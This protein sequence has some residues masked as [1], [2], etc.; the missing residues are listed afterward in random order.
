MAL[1]GFDPSVLLNYYAVKLTPG[2]SPGVASHARQTQTRVVPPWDLSIKK[3]PQ[4]KADVAARSG[5]P[6]FDPK[7]RSLLAKVDGPANADSQ[8]AAL[9]Q[10][11]LAHRSAGA[12]DNPGLDADNNRLFALYKALNRLDSIARM[13]NREETTNGRRPGLNG[14]FQNGLK[15][16]VDFVKKAEFNNLTVLPNAKASTTQSAVAIAYPKLNYTSGPV[17][18]DDEVFS[19]VPNVTAADS[20]TISVT[21]AGV[22]TDVDIDLANVS[23]TLTLDNINAYVNQQLEAGGFGTRFARV[24]TGGSIVEGTAT[25]GTEIRMA[26]SEVINLSS[27]QSSPAVYVAGSTGKGADLQGRVI[28]LGDLD[29]AITSE[30]AANITPT[31][32]TAAAKASAIDAN[33]NVYVV[34]NSSGSFGS[35][36]NQGS[37]DAFLTKYD[38][39]GN[40][41]WTKLLG[42]ANKA[43]A[44]AVAVDP[45]SGGVVVAGSV[46][47][48]LKPTAIGGGTDSFVAKFD[49]DGNQTWLRQVAPASN[50]SANALTIDDSGN[51][52]FGGQVTGVI[53]SGQTNAGGSDAYLTKLDAQGTLLYNRQFGGAGDDAARHMAIADDGNVVVASVQNGHAILTKYDSADGT[54][55]A[56]WQLDLG[57][58]QGG[59]IGGL[60][61]SGG[62]IY[63]SGTSTNASLDAAGAAGIAQASSGG[64][65]AFVFAA[66]DGGSS[67][68]ADFVS[69]VGTAASEQGGGVAVAN[70]KIYLTGTT[71]GTFPGQ[72]VNGAG[73][74]NQFVAQLD[75][76]GTVDWTRQYGGVAGE[77]QGVSIVADETGSSVLGAL[78]L[79]RGTLHSNQSNRIESQTTAR[80]G[81]YFTLKIEGK[82][83]TREAKITIA[84]GETLRSL[85]VKINAALLFDGKA[86]ALP[87]K[88][89][90]GLKIAVNDGAQIQLI[91]GPKDFDALA[92]LGL[93]PQTLVHDA[94]DKNDSSSNTIGLGIDGKLDLLSKSTAAHA[95]V[96]MQAAMALIKQAYG[97]LNTPPGQTQAVQPGAGSAYQQSRL[98]NYQSALA[99]MNLQNQ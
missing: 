47:G 26:P 64:N 57:D 41:Q 17:V 86:T 37:E 6:Y 13:A 52:Y 35:E 85:A 1:T 18:E 91:A 46:T 20:F 49:T 16:I 56:L 15:Q 53:A 28:K 92:G 25:W 62:Q 42:S 23:G 87:I 24:Q 96:V 78:K 54:S 81:D 32:G 22:T 74:H 5:D 93:K 31:D 58:L 90:Q 21:K 95:D 84:K 59:S 99:W 12:S 80:A 10:T 67:V 94:K 38:S 98:A 97:K 75:A 19:A 8:L 76:D 2:A 30:F 70:G 44:Y 65:D 63:V 43:S 71:I 4:E 79:P 83:A 33:G 73:A 29:G 60:T 68:T 9:L 27:A 45:A 40:V 55:A 50:D 72:A 11:T 34:G 36:L 69:Y 51:I 7:D 66:V 89:G 14:D 3:L 82:T 48:D 77:S 61:I 39:A 88:G